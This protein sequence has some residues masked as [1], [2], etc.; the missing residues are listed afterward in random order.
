MRKVTLT[1][2]AGGPAVLILDETT[3]PP[4]RALPDGWVNG[5]LPVPASQMQIGNMFRA[6]FPFLAYRGNCQVSLDI[7]AV[8]RFATHEAAQDFVGQRPYIARVGELAIFSEFSDGTYTRYYKTA[9]LT[10]PKPTKDGGLR[11]EFN[12][13]FLL[14]SQYSITP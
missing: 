2:V 14:N 8:H 11:Q 13:T 12:Y 5:F 1:P 4:G 10:V 9:F 7:Q 3:A 6:A